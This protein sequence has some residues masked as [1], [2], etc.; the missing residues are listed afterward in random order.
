MDINLQDGVKITM[1]MEITKRLY[2]YLLDISNRCPNTYL[3]IVL[4]QNDIVEKNDLIIISQDC[5]KIYPTVAGEL[6][7]LKDNLFMS[8][9]AFNPIIF[10]EVIALLRFLNNSKEEDNFWNMIHSAIV[11][12][13]KGL[14]VDGHYA[15]ALEDAFVEVNA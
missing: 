10:R 7:R 4:L 6:F 1:K 13:S 15:N 5:Q 12:V 11:R 3:P 14:F 9:G 8:Q 2:R